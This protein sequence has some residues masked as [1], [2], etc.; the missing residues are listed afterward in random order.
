MDFI[1]E[2]EIKMNE[3]QHGV[4]LLYRDLQEFHDWSD[5]K[6]WNEVEAELKRICTVGQ[7]GEDDLAWTREVLTS[8]RDVNLWEAVRLSMRFK[9]QTPLLDAMHNLK[10]SYHK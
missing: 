2:I 7:F 3:W 6:V 1:K 5:D 10:N 4:R 9:N 8:R